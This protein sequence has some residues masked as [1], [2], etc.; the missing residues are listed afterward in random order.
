[1]VNGKKPEKFTTLKSP[2]SGE[3]LAE[4]PSASLEDVELAIESAY[5]ARKTMAALPSHKR[6]AI[7]EKLA[8]LLESR[9]DEAAEIIAKEAAK[10][11]KTAMVEVSRTI[12]TYKFA[13][14][15]AKRIHGETLTMDATADGEGR[16]GYTV[17][18]PIGV[19]GAITPFNFPMNLV[20]HKVGPAIAAGNPTCLETC[21]PNTTIFAISC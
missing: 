12:A 9:K 10:P 3:V 18:E 2:Y 4:I 20:A 8:S 19:V 11:I 6:A 21:E 13:A 5:Q 17:R 16:I 14:E 1:M 7:L 15:E